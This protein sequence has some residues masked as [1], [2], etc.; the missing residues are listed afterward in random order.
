MRIAIDSDSHVPLF[1]QIS[2]AIRYEIA[3]GRLVRGATLPSIRDAAEQWGVHYLTVRRAYAALRDEGLVSSRAGVG[4]RVTA[5]R[6]GDDARGTRTREDGNGPSTARSGT[7]VASRNRAV[8]SVVECNAP[9]A[10]DYA[11]QVSATLDAP[12][13]TW[14]L[15]D[16]GDPPPG[17]IVGT[18][19]H[20]N[21]IRAR[22]PHRGADLRFVSVVID[23]DLTRRLGEFA[24][25]DEGP[26][27]VRLLETDP[28]RAHNALPDLR[29]LL[30]SERFAVEPEVVSDLSSALVARRDRTPVLLSPRLWRLAGEM[31][32]AE[33][34][35]VLL[36]YLVAPDDLA[37]LRDEVR[38]REPGSARRGTARG[39]ERRAS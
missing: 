1:E 8:V 29:T 20:F 9:Q 24:G 38:D 25:D 21:E 4:T 18:Y 19:F 37:A 17:W 28:S 32:R 16:E 36:R 23:P 14:L 22:W 15:S 12:V 2:R 11:A 34:G 10:S 3:V 30:P 26:L 33:E 5:G 7:T 13:G 27:R 6:R 35:V 39:A 31:A